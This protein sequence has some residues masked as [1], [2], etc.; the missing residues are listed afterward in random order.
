MEGKEL[1]DAI[2]LAAFVL[3]IG[4]IITAAIWRVVGLFSKKDSTINKAYNR[5]L[6]VQIDADKELAETNHQNLKED[7]VK[8][9]SQIAT[10]VTSMSNLT[11]E[12]KVSNEI[13]K[14]V[15]ATNKKIL[16]GK[17]DEIDLLRRDVDLHEQQVQL[18]RMKTEEEIK[19]SRDLQE[20]T[21][22]RVAA[23]M[24]GVEVMLSDSP[25]REDLLKFREEIS[26]RFD[27]I[28]SHTE[29]E[30]DEIRKIVNLW[31]E[32]TNGKC[33]NKMML[34]AIRE[35]LHPEDDTKLVN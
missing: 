9:E 17:D 30:F 8:V 14:E 21:K 32:F 23:I 6:K 11:T 3:T 27:K 2:K 12:I 28:E 19:L 18:E 10:L 5:A 16:I 29:E 31:E 35:M 34:T 26:E 4:A 15:A 7:V 22:T 25:L 24:E 13:S 20:T 33:K 1:A